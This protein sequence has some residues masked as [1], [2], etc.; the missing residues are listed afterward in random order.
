[1]K[2]WVTEM[3]PLPIE[4]PKE[5]TEGEFMNGGEVETIKR[6]IVDWDGMASEATVVAVA[7]LAKRLGAE[8]PE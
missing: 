7:A 3:K 5:P 1:M 2:P 6:L 4:V 8:F